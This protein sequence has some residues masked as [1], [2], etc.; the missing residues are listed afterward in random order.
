MV[1]EEVM[2][3]PGR[4]LR[5]LSKHVLQ[6]RRREAEKSMANL[7]FKMNVLTICVSI[8][9]IQRPFI[10]EFLSCLQLLFVE[11]CLQY[12]GISTMA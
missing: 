5:A 6:K 4:D 1:S 3:G 9:W 10:F 8:C 11:D 12:L 2:K 7:N